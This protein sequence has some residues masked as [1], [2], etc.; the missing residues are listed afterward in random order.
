MTASEATEWVLQQMR[1][2]APEMLTAVDF[3]GRSYAREPPQA[4]L[5]S[6]VLT[7]TVGP[8]QSEVK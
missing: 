8:I 4:S 2:N 3:F 5:M 1:A 7:P 6:P